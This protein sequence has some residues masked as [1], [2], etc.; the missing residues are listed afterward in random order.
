[1]NEKLQGRRSLQVS[2][3]WTLV[4]KHLNLYIACFGMIS[5]ASIAALVDPMMIRWIIDQKIAAARIGP[6]LLFAGLFLL[7]Y[8][9]RVGFQAAG[10]FLAFKA[11]QLIA[12]DIRVL[13][14]EAIYRQDPGF[15]EINTVGN[16]MFKV[17]HDVEELCAL[18]GE[19]V[20]MFLRTIL[21]GTCVIAMLLYLNWRLSAIVLPTLPVFLFLQARQ[22]RV[23]EQKA[24]SVQDLCGHASS[25]LQESLGSV[26]QVRL[27]GRESARGREYGDLLSSVLGAMC[28]R[29]M[30]ELMCGFSSMTLIAVGLSIIFGYG[31]Y[32][33][34]RG[35][36]T[37]GALVAFYA[38]LIRLFDPLGSVID[39]ASRYQRFKASCI[40]LTEVLERQPKV[41]TLVGARRCRSFSG[42][43]EFRGVSFSYSR[44]AV[45]ENI[46]FKAEPGEKIAIVGPTGSGKST[47]AKL[48][49]R[50]YDPDGGGILFDG[51]DLRRLDLADVRSQI[52]AVPQDPILFRKSIREN[53]LYGNPDATQ[54]ELERA[55]EIAQLNRTLTEFPGEFDH[56]LEGCDKSISGGQRQ[57][58][59]IARALLQK[60]PVLLLDE[61]TSALDAATEER[62]LASLDEHI[63]AAGQTIIAIAHRASVGSWAD[64][65]VVIH[66]GRL[67]E[68]GTYFQLNRPGKFYFDL[69]KSKS[70]VHEDRLVVEGRQPLPAGL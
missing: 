57:R 7:A 33:V 58:L 42:K 19:T 61:A 68:E 67:I 52:A 39:M 70:G 6:L 8:L 1:M 30:Y 66:H 38:Y 11:A 64:R 16:L 41:R 31:G 28:S 9:G 3:L 36:L 50:F 17:D 27:L 51:K 54:R 53:L 46:S 26:A 18:G 65:I 63:R 25:H 45:L 20:P 5:A 43:I 55:V 22:R 23:I 21:M 62:L 47:I 10:V 59:A 15:F 29:R 2:W 24:H 48:A 34:I 35:L 49:V 32:L 44:L 12:R 37:V 14:F 4:R 40:R 60:R 56:V 13:L 69:I